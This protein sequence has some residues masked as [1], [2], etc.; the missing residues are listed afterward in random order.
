MDQSELPEEITALLKAAEQGDSDAQFNLGSIYDEGKG[1][2]QND[3][4]AIEWYSKA[5]EQG[6]TDAQ[7]NLGLMYEAGRGV[8]QSDHKAVE[9][10]HKAAQQGDA[11]AQFC[12]GVMYQK[13]KGVEQSNSTA[14][15]WYH[16]A[17]Q[18]GDVEAQYYLGLM[19]QRGE[20]VEQSDSSA[21][22]WFSKAAEQGDTDAQF[23]LGMMYDEGRGVV[24]SHSMAVE[25][26]HKAAEKGHS[27]AQF[28]LGLKYHQGL[29]VAQRDS[30]AAVEW[31]H[32]ASEQGFA[33]AQC[34]LALMYM[35]GQGVEQ[36]E[37]TAL[38][39]FRKASRGGSVRGTINLAL[40]Y[41]HEDGVKQSYAR[42]RAL[43]RK[44]IRNASPELRFEAL[45]FQDQAERYTLSPQITKI[46]KQILEKLKAQ[47]GSTMTHY[48]SLLVG[49]ALLLEPSAL[50]LGHINALNDPN[51]G[52]LL[53]RHLGH[54]PVE[55]KPA[56]VGC[57]LP[58]EDSLNMWRFYSKDH[59][60]EDAC[61]CAITFNTDNFFEFDLLSKEPENALQDAKNQ[62]FLNSGKSPQ[63]SA[64]FYRV[65]Y[66][67]GEMQIQGEDDDGP[68]KQLLDE[69]KTE[70]NGFLGTAPDKEKLQQLSWLLGPLPYLLKD[71]DYE[72]EKE[73]RIIV[74]HLEY[75]A[76]EIQVQEPNLMEGT[77]PRLYLEMHRANHLAPIKHVTLG[78]KSPHQEMMAPYWHHQLA[79]KFPE[80][81]K[82]K[83]DFY[84]K[85]SKCAYQ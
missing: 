35:S 24:Q 63:E 8:V 3:S 1:V 85:A 13:G 4:T 43:F 40:L 12:L 28:K 27:G 37:R 82:A 38:K 78:P 39:W 46:R 58:D 70:V 32:K 7:F 6:Y 11:E 41:M 79:S 77:P 47:A 16:K 50:R 59:R 48:T 23:T 71:A 66:I 56:F 34:N 49:N 57:F 83:P 15:E 19:Y 72:A 62:A 42:A 67:K 65:V 33:R 64:A 18:Q 51:E 55:S 30:T 45:E 26:Y 25:Y 36:N 14:V 61:G 84:I 9:W 10:Y 76:K 53:W 44:A 75:G 22:E 68:L 5:A 52:K 20:G 81:L 54:S 31:Y 29:G 80:Q 74:T 73:H 17:A 69:L 2:E 60:K 21:I